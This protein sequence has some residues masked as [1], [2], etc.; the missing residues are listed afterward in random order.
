[1]K[2]QRKCKYAHLHNFALDPVELDG[3]YIFLEAELV[4]CLLNRIGEVEPNLE[5]G[6][7]EHRVGGA[8]LHVHHDREGVHRAAQIEHV[9]E[10]QGV[11]LF[12]G[13]LRRVLLRVAIG[14]DSEIDFIELFIPKYF[15]F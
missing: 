4:R 11:A 10:V 8:L 6:V 12:L 15:F 5:P 1:M 2:I 14:S 3:G 13:H 9:R 7:A